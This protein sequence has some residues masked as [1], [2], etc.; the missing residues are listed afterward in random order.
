[1]RYRQP[2]GARY[3]DCLRYIFF[4]SRSEDKLMRVQ[5]D[6]RQGSHPPSQYEEAGLQYNV[7]LTKRNST[8]RNVKNN[9]DFY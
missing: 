9:Y 6:S 2:K 7:S 5:M 4:K 1:M 3:N 8:S